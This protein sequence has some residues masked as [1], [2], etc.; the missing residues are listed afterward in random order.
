MTLR[1]FRIFLELYEERNMTA[2]AAK[3]YITQPSVSQALKEMEEHYEAKLF[4][5]LSN[6][7]FITEAGEEV[8]HYASHIVSLASE[9]EG[10]MKGVNLNKRLMIGANY[11]VGTFLIHNY[12]EQFQM[13]FPQ[14]QVNIR[15]NKASNLIEMLRN[16][17]LDFILIEERQGEKD[18]TQKFFQNDRIVFAVSTQHELAQKA[19][20]DLKELLSENF[21]LREKGAG[22]RD[23]FDAKMFEQGYKIEPYWESTSTTALIQAT[24][25]SY[26]IGVF[27]YELVKEEFLIGSLRELNIENLDFSRKL[28][29]ALHKNKFLSL[30]MEEFINIVLANSS[31][32]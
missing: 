31:L 2:A 21:L 17:K 20:I 32:S 11:T 7:L 10:K 15:V 13:I 30:E 26:G 9:L 12:I 25:R 28:V 18:L 3:L 19:S 27:P 23:L 4:E 24:K 8:Y 22:V 16:N 6:R 29:I 1:H 5:R 14:T